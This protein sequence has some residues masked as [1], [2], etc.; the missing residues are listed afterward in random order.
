MNET[1][2]IAGASWRARARARGR[3]RARAFALALAAA[4][5]VALGASTAARAH[6]GH[7]HE[8]DQPSPAASATT[9]R[10]AA[11]SDAFELVGALDGRRMT[12]WL[13]R[14]ADNAPVTG[15]SI[16]IEVG[17]AKAVAKATGD[18]YVAELAAL[19]AMGTLP[20]TATIVAAGAS[21]LLASEIVLGAA[22]PATP[23]GS[24]AAAAQAWAPALDRRVVVASAV[25]AIVAGLLGWGL[26]RRRA[27]GQEHTA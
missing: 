26:A 12:L 6:E 20:V 16:E 25:S 14:F 17:D 23:G 3:G 7:D 10:F 22:G 21:D 19:P 9:P 24:T 27:T 5:G 8:G 1:R 15:A 11:A 4:F 2:T 18:V 13:D